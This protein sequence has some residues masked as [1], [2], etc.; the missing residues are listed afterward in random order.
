MKKA[1]LL[2]ATIV[3]LNIVLTACNKDNI[4]CTNESE[5]CGFISSEEFDNTGPLTDT[6]LKKLDS[7]LS[8]QEKLEKLVN[9]LKCKRCVANAEIFCN[10]CIETYPAQSELK[11]W[12][13]VNGQQIEKTLDITMSDPLR[14]RTYHD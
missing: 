9:W 12:F 14:F 3:F 1:R 11:V 7:D 4:R 5:F 8:A 10:S 6:F 2:L 13:L